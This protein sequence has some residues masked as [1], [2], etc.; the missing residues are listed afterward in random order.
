[1]DD[2]FEILKLIYET[3]QSTAPVTLQI[4]YTIGT[5]C[6]KGIVFKEAAPAIINRLIEHG[7]ICDLKSYGLHIFKL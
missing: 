6:H 3:A 2:N 1:M 4:G 5:T 7:Y